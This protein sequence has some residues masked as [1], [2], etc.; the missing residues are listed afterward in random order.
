MKGLISVR[1][2]SME[3]LAGILGIYRCH[4]ASLTETRSRKISDRAK[5]QTPSSLWNSRGHLS[6]VLM[7]CAVKHQQEAMQEFWVSPFTQRLSWNKGGGD[8][9][10]RLF[11]VTTRFYSHRPLQRCTT[12]SIQNELEEKCYLVCCS[13]VLVEQN[14]S[15]WNLIITLRGTNVCLSTCVFNRSNNRKTASVGNWTF[16]WDFS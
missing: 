6:S 7:S 16:W 10:L 13:F 5:R 2:C 4:E 14:S 11:E 12:P 9:V 1:C 3:V 15:K 8:V